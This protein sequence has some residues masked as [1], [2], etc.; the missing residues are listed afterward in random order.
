MRRFRTQ[1]KRSAAGIYRQDGWHFGRGLRNRQQPAKP[2]F[3]V[4]GID[5]D[6]LEVSSPGL[7][8]PLKRLADFQRFIGQSAKVKLHSR[9]GD[10]KRFDGVIRSVGADGITFALVEA[11]VAPA[12]D[13]TRS[14][15][16]IGKAA[17]GKHKASEKPSE[18]KLITVPL[19]N[20]DRARLIPE[21]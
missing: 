9:I 16:T 14:P 17:K 5:F 21:I 10:R 4:E 12:P 8:R 19:E 15:K 2:G 7:D 1:C 13:N 3:L 11:P 6:R 20:I 18:A